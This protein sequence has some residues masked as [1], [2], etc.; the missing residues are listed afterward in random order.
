[1]FSALSLAV[2]LL[3]RSA[4]DGSS[5]LCVFLKR[6]VDLK[7]MESNGRFKLREVVCY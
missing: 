4:L 7:L 2:Y 5:G 1:M 3:A 6:F